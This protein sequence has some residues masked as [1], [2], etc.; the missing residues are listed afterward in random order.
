MNFYAIAKGKQIGVF[1]TWAECKLYTDGFKGA[2]FK[3]F[4]TNQEAEEFIL[5]KR[6]QFHNTKSNITEV[7]NTFFEP[8]YYVY[9]DGSC[10]NNGKENALAGI[11]IYF[12]ENDIRNISQQVVGK[13]TNNTAE[14]GAILHLY[15]IIENDILTGK[16]IGIVSDSEYAI[17]CVTSY[18]KRCEEGGWKKDIPNKDMIKNTYELY[19]DK[20]NV[21]FLHIKAHT[22]NTDIHSI[23][24]DGA[25]KLANKAIGLDVCPY[26]KIYLLVPFS[27][28]EI[29]KEFGGR[30]DAS[31]KLWYIFKESENKEHV[32]SLFKTVV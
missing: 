4:K 23:G 12:G 5:E 18:G 20:S 7:E 1:H 22:G 19:K 21:T 10:S 32:L 30:W 29:V 14:L 8:D 2:V 9:T 26:T 3:K 27:Q 31:R 17:K 11:G 28:K 15:N 25:D 24:N 6:N 13:Q 16:K